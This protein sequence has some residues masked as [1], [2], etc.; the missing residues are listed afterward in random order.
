[1]VGLFVFSFTY[2]IHVYYSPSMFRGIPPLLGWAPDFVFSRSPPSAM[3]S[4]SCIPAGVTSCLWW[5]SC[6]HCGRVP[7]IPEAFLVSFSFTLVYMQI[8]CQPH[9]LHIPRTSTCFSLM[10]DYC[11]LI[12]VIPESV[13]LCG[14]LVVF[15]SPQFFTRALSHG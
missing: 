7:G 11:L 12:C 15:V 6:V 5:L 8:L 4:P 2:H 3:S 13:T 1:M 14:T 10:R 9:V